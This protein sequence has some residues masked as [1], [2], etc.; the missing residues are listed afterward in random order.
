MSKAKELNIEVDEY[1]KLLRMAKTGKVSVIYNSIDSKKK[2]SKFKQPKRSRNDTEGK[3]NTN[4]IFGNTEQSVN[5]RKQT[6]H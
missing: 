1:I 3:Q 5:T 2:K 6:I 4:S